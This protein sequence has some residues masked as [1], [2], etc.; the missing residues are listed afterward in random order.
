VNPV[1]DPWTVNRLPK[2]PGKKFRVKAP[3]ILSAPNEL[4]VITPPLTVK[5]LAATEVK[6]ARTL[7]GSV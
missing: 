4:A 7:K 1:P 2:V 3:P 6:F 5:L